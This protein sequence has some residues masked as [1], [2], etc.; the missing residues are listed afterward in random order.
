MPT[1][2]QG[3]TETPVTVAGLGSTSTADL[4]ICFP[5]SPLYDG[6]YTDAKL[7]EIYTALVLDP[8]IND[9]GHTFGIFNRG[10]AGAP[11]LSD[12][13]V[14][15]GGKPGTPFAPNIASPG[16]GMNPRN[17]PAAGAAATAEQ[18][19]GGG[20]GIGDGLASP[21]DTSTKVATSSRRLGDLIFGQA[22]RR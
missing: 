22:Y 18:P 3:T 7:K 15:G 6:T 11:K 21:D 5:G 14:G 16:P 8:V 12:V 2:R 17:I 1:H 13:A 9:G 4:N 19:H 10:F 20:Y